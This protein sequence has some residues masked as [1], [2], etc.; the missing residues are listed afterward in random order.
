MV[1]GKEP[2]RLFKPR[3]VFWEYLF[4]DPTSPFRLFLNNLNQD[5]SLNFDHLLGRINV[6]SNDQYD[7]GEVS[8]FQ[9]PT[10]SPITCDWLNTYG[11]LLAFTS[12]FGIT[13]LHSD[14]ALVHSRG[15]QIVDIECLFWNIELP[16]ET[17]LLPRTTE[18]LKRCGLY[19]TGLVSLN[20]M[21]ADEVKTIL[22]GIEK[23]M[24]FF[25]RHLENIQNFFLQM[26]GE[27]RNHPIRILAK[28]T[29]EYRNYLDGRSTR[30]FFNEEI[31]QLG[32]NDIP[33]FYGYIDSE[34]VYYFDTPS[35]V[36]K[37][38]SRDSELDLKVRRAFKNPIELLS[39]ER[40]TRLHKQIIA[41]VTYRLLDFKDLPFESESFSVKSE[42][43]YIK[44]KASKYL[45]QM[46]RK[47]L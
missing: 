2:L 19:F 43:Q 39:S 40:I 11:Q 25:G 16:S 18:E 26:E 33:Y 14:N 41:E 34:D 44:I 35:H 30:I 29:Q 5:T 9:C 23:I 12:I 10:I 37:V 13:D 31:E 24:V 15:I 46:K 22:S 3:T 20:S 27:L 47:G 38:Q 17:S 21:T 4:L 28:H 1:E 7:S 36:Q 42:D 8:F 32:R 6:F 45:I